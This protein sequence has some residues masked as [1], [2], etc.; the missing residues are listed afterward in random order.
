MTYK[1]A[2]GKQNR[3]TMRDK[4]TIVHYY[5]DYGSLNIRDARVLS[6]KI[7]VDPKYITCVK[8]LVWFKEYCQIYD[9]VKKIVEKERG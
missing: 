8:D 9:Y 7:G 6:T 3:L 4:L 2:D 1:I 5:K